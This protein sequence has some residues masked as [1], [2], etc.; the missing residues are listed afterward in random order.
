MSMWANV[1]ADCVWGLHVS[2]YVCT[3]IL[4]IYLQHLG[5]YK[6]F[7]IHKVGTFLLFLATDCNKS[8]FIDCFFKPVFFLMY[9]F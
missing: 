6:K 4:F 7:S 2:M 9:F 5:D 8:I 1:R 3:F